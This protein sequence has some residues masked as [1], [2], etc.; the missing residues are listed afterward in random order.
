MEFDK[1]VDNGFV[2]NFRIDRNS[3]RKRESSDRKDLFYS[4]MQQTGIKVRTKFL[5][6]QEIPVL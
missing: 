2:T 6:N 1:L 5:N 4:L 3:M